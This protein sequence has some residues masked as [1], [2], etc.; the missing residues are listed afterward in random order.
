MPI[1][2]VLLEPVVRPLT[3]TN[4]VGLKASSA[5]DDPPDIPRFHRKRLV[6]FVIWK[7]KP[8]GVEESAPIIGVNEA[9]AL[10]VTD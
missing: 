3:E 4:P 9:P 6:K 1:V 7:A 2:T 5:V 8:A 10:T